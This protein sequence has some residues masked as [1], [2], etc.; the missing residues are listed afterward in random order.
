MPR[1]PQAFLQQPVIVNLAVEGDDNA[2]IQ[3]G[4]GLLA[5][6]E[7]DDGQPAMGKSQAGFEMKTIT[8]RPP[9]TNGVAHGLDDRLV[10]F[11]VIPAVEPSRD[12]AHVRNSPQDLATGP[13][14]CPTLPAG[15]SGTA[16]PLPAAVAPG[17]DRCRQALKRQPART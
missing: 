4:H 12:P 2:A 10:G 14:P 13:R 5:G 11:S 7:I 6:I 9:M 17:K 15:R 16:R 3:A 8:I 1:L